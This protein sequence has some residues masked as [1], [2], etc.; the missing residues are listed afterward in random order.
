MI[1]KIAEGFVILSLCAILALV[2]WDCWKA[3]QVMQEEI[4][5]EKLRRQTRNAMLTDRQ[6]AR[7]KKHN[8]RARVW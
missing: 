7:L 8:R 2:I 1:E 6:L 3:D 5:R 4:E